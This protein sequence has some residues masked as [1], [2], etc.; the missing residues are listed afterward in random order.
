MISK[1][2]KINGEYC[3]Q[4][5]DKIIQPLAFKSFR[6]TE[7][8]VKEFYDAGV[9]LFHVYCSGLPSGLKV[10]Y[11]LYG[12][13]WFGDHNY[14]FDN[15]DKQIEF[16]K[17]NA[18]EGYVF[19]N[20]H[21]DVRQWWL[22]E[23]KGNPNSFTHLSQ[24]ACNDKWKKDTADYLKALIK[25]V[26][27]KYNDFVIG[28]FLLGGYT[29]EWFS[30]FDNEE[31]HP[32]KERA[33]KKYMHNNKI[34]IP[35]KEIL[36]RP[37]DEIILRNNTSEIINYRRFHNLLIANLVLYF[38]HEAQ[39][40]IKHKKILGMFFGYIL[41]LL[42]ARMWY[43]GH[44]EFDLINKSKDI[45]LLATPSSYQFRSF[46][47]TGAYMLLCDSLELNK[48]ACF[49]SFDHTTYLV[50]SLPKNKERL[51]NDPGTSTALTL[52]AQMRSRNKKD[53]LID[54]F[55]TIE[56]M[57]REF[58]QKIYK[59]T[60][61]WWFDMFEGWF[62]DKNLM[63]EVKHEVN[64][65]NRFSNIAKQSISEVAVFFSGQSLY[66]MNKLSDIN[67][68]TIC[69]QRGGL[70][71]MGCPYDCYSL[72]DLESIDTSKYKLL[73][74]VESLFLTKKQRIII[75][76][77]K[78][79]NIT[80]LFIGPVDFASKGIESTNNLLGMDLKLV[81]NKEQNI[82]CQNT[83]FGYSEPKY[84]SYYVFDSDCQILGKYKESHKTA[85]ALKK[86]GSANIIFSGIGNL[87]YLSLQM[88]LKIA[89]VHIYSNQGI[90]TFVSNRFIG[91]YSPEIPEIDI[92][93]LKDGVYEEI[94]TGNLYTS[95]NKSIVLDTKSHPA[96][97]LF[98]VI[99]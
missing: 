90:A 52:L 87:D 60:G 95:K 93:L 66:Y 71:K 76:N 94:F 49:I 46:D 34:V 4:V 78:K 36:E 75:N 21:L 51:C 26:E 9:R 92:Q 56:A 16:F 57:R 8:N 69:N 38:A 85:F 63:Q 5:N 2:Y 22:D 48:K 35:S 65:S 97:M 3:F 82:I 24:I 45:D 20:I 37:S 54:K 81:C 41:E 73:I 30:E 62:Y 15:L 31:T 14:N 86:Y 67:T 28:Y 7:K 70:N 32:N 42:S 39:K 68:E 99:K 29:T 44:I 58:M 11:S 23:N 77:L 33:Y 61:Y 79:N 1:I 6:P 55:Q 10:P 19:I 40:I 50:P 53:L 18:P 89:G 59:R 96:Q 13:T 64:L 47:S 84:D 80:M 43:A 17:A 25:H 98:E 91:V 12:E 74:F 88:V 83:S 72:N 27:E